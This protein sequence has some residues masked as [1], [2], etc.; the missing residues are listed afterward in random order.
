MVLD[1]E[2]ELFL[3]VRSHGWT[4][5]ANIE[6]GERH[7]FCPSSRPYVIPIELQ[8]FWAQRVLS[9]YPSTS[10]W[11]AQCIPHCTADD[12]MS[13]ARPLFL[14]LCQH[15]R[16]ASPPL[17]RLFRGSPLCNN[18]SA[19]SLGQQIHT[20]CVYEAPSSARGDLIQRQWMFPR[21]RRRFSTTPVPAHGHTT[22]PKPGEEY[23]PNISSIQ[24]PVLTFQTP[25]Y[26]SHSS[27]KKAPS[28]HSKSQPVTT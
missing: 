11:Q 7:H 2:A 3:R 24:R 13:N 8:S 16:P 21:A 5:N 12:S 1:V 15:V 17:P 26:T 27:T 10:L 9:T 20:G 25:D 28:T 19:R 23:A 18:P 4:L 6:S 14:S 22:P